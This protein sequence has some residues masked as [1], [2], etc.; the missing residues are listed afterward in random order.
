MLLKDAPKVKSM[1]EPMFKILRGDARQLIG[2]LPEVH[3][4][5]TS[6]PYHQKRV[7]GNSDREVGRNEDLDDYINDLVDI[8]K[9]IPLHPQGS[10]WVNIGD[11]RSAE[12]GLCYIPARFGLEMMKAGFILRDHVI[13]VKSQ[14][15]DDGT[16][17]GNRMTEPCPDRLNGNGHE[18][19][20][21]F[22]KS[23]NAWADTVAVQ[24]L[25]DNVSPIRYLP[26]DLMT[27]V[28]SLHG[29]NLD[30]V[31]H[32]GMGQTRER[33]YGVFPPV[34]C[35]RPIAM[36]CPP[37]VNPDGTLPRRLVEAEQ[38]DEGR[39]WRRTIGKSDPDSSREKKGRH[40]TGAQYIARM[41]VTTGWEEI[42]PD[43]TP[44]I[45]LDPFAGT[46]TAGEVALKL[47]RSFYGIELYQ[48]YVEIACRRCADARAY[49]MRNYGN[50]DPVYEMIKNPG[51][52]ATIRSW[53]EAAN[54]AA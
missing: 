16:R 52:R 18:G 40:D 36:T 24:M 13:W 33:H 30:N 46:G 45:V 6:P 27:A 23:T 34:L 11:K 35:E 14:A 28:T 44:G 9:S 7:Y 29:S 1:V 51:Q 42:S 38:Y 54:A 8:F 17:D 26:E 41:P 4:V 5:V 50:Y 48:E 19:I 37:F 3:C 25:R 32:M 39:G 21:H 2:N 49:V 43:A 10:I 20:L 31:W 15:N 47:G 22:I 53:F 12:G